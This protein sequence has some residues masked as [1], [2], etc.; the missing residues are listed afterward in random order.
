[1]AKQLLFNKKARKSLVKG[2]EKV[3][4]AVRVTLGSRGRNVVFQVGDIQLSTK[5]G[6]TVARNVILSDPFENMGAGFVKEVSTKTEKKVGD[7]TSTSIVLSHSIIKEGMKHVNRGIAPVALKR[8]IDKAVE[9]VVSEI[10]K[11]AKPLVDKQDI[12]DV[13]TI[14]ANG[15]IEIGNMMAD[16]IEQVTANGVISIDESQTEKTTLEIVKGMEWDS[17]YASPYFCTDHKT[18]EIK[19]NNV[20]ILIAE[21]EINHAKDIERALT[22]AV[23]EEKPL[24][25]IAKEIKG[26]A[27]QALTL[28]SMK[29]SVDVVAVRAPGYEERRTSLMQDIA[30]MTGAQLISPDMGLKLQDFNFAQFGLAENITVTKNSTTIVATDDTKQAIE[31]RA[32]EIQ[33]LIDEAEEFSYAEKVQKERLGKLSGGVAII[34]VGAPTESELQEKKFRVVDAKHATLSGIK[35]GIIAGGGTLLAKISKSL[36]KINMTGWTKEEKIGF[37]IVLKAIKEPCRQIAS[38]AGLNGYKVVKNVMRAESGIG[39][40]ATTL[41]YVHMISKGILDPAKVTRTA[42]ENASSI[43]GL[44]LTTECAIVD[45]KEIS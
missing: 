29:G 9:L 10:L 31:E 2:I 25:I 32:E 45:I 4:N 12:A 13:A 33:A 16:A 18:P 21:Y 41:Q 43:A 8:G 38:N 26:E 7:G 30:I 24:L 40:N 19:K 20:L 15:D 17:G 22:L 34:K 11:S 1:M 6:A 27:L 28:N 5:D 37:R 36:E 42:L 23:K 39:F 14:S 3:S 35:E 44:I